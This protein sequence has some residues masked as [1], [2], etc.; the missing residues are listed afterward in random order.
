MPRVQGVPVT[1]LV[2][3]FILSPGGSAPAETDHEYGA[4]PP[5]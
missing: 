4:T 2:V 3:E 5:P 1:S